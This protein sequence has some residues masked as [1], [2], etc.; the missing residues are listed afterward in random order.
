M[1][2]LTQ[3]IAKLLTIVMILLISACATTDPYTGEER[4]SRTGQGAAIGAG[5]GAVI[6]AISGGD[7]LERAAIG[8]GIGAL[9][10]AAIGNYMDRQEAE[11]RRQ[12]EGTGVSVTRRGDEIILNMPGNV[13]F[14]FDSASL[15]SEFFDVL[16][17]VALVLEEYEKTVL[18]IDGHTDSTGPRSY[19]MELSERRAEAVG[20]YLVSQGINSVR[21]ATYGY[22]P[23]HPIASNET[24][25]G[26]TA[27]RRVELTLMPITEE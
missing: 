6:G 13:T 24:E 8:A 2:T 10:G 5:V 22:G 12:L 18:V 23:D 9:S 1:R 11:L 7:R 17:S 26:R 27:N 4:T 15:R 21:L 16:E 19:N 25:A 20:D 14:D 3:K